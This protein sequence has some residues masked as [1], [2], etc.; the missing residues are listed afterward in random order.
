MASH[1]EGVK[2][3]HCDVLLISALNV[4][5]GVAPNHDV[6][7]CAQA[8]MHQAM[9]SILIVMAVVKNILSV[10]DQTKHE[11]F[12]YSSTTPGNT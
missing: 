6:T 4:R 12:C 8:P 11:A 5:L 7:C 2:R 9:V 3:E 10:A 1:S